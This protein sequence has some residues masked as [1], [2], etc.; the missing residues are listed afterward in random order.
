M[1]LLI[2]LK[3]SF[4]SRWQV[5][6]Y[7]GN[8]LKCVQTFCTQAQYLGRFVEWIHWQTVSVVFLFAIRTYLT[9]TTVIGN[10]VIPR[11]VHV[12]RLYYPFE[13]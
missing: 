13:L 10:G 4:I 5:V 9:L 11:V 12:T 1:A 8:V 7:S 6:T 3:S 2:H